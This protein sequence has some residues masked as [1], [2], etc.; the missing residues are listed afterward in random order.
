MET[1]RRTAERSQIPEI[2]APT[3]PPAARVEPSVVLNYLEQGWKED[4][5]RRE[6]RPDPDDS[7]HA[8]GAESG[9]TRDQ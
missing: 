5:G 8:N 7:E 9:V 6:C 1:E 2:V 4:E 3:L